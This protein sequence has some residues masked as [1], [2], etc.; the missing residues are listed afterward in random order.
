MC[1]RTA[2]ALFDS[3]IRPAWSLLRMIAVRAGLPE[4]KG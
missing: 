3:D 1:D 2:Q 4:E